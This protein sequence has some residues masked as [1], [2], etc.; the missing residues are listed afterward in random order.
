[1]YHK[2][3][4]L[5]DPQ[6]RAGS[7]F[8]RLLASFLVCADPIRNYGLDQH[9]VIVIHSLQGYCSPCDMQAVCSNGDV[10]FSQL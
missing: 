9:V 10:T 4:A 6:R 8:P 3:D 2:V 5:P 1:M 7:F